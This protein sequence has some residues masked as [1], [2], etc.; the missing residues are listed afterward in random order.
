M[1]QTVKQ[2]ILASGSPRRRELLE[3]LG[4]SFSI[5]VPEIDESQLTGE[6]AQDYVLRMAQIKGSD[7]GNRN[8]SAWIVSADTVVI[9]DG[10]LLTKP[11]TPEQAVEMLMLL[12]GREHQV[13]TG[14][15][16]SCLDEG[17]SIVDNCISLV[18]FKSFDI[19]WARSYV[20]TGEPM[21]KAGGYGIQDRGGVLVQTVNGSYSNVVGL[22]LAE[23][24]DL[25]SRFG[26]VLPGGKESDGGEVADNG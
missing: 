5:V 15:C 2:L 24:V 6:S 13:Q 17:V 18:R 9:S 20:A 19:T 4:I 26:V 7:V 1:F 21:D 14:F 10:Q 11:E 22:P 12:S 8:P 23:T 25:L 3:K 16:L